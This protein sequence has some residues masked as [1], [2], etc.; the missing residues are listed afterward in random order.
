MWLDGKC[1]HNFCRD[2]PRPYDERLSKIMVL[3]LKYLM[4]ESGAVYGYT[5]SDEISL[6]L[7]A[8]DYK[9]QMYFDGKIQKITSVL[10]SCCV[11]HFNE[12]K[13]TMLTDKDGAM[14]LFD[15]RV[16]NVPDLIEAANYILWRE[17]DAVR[18]SISMAAQSVFSHT[19]L[20]GASCN[21]MQDMLHDKGI[22]WNDY[23][24]FF[25]RGTHVRRIRKMTKFST[26]EIEKLPDKHESRKNPD[27]EIERSVL[28]D[29]GIPKFSSISNKVGFMFNGEEPI[30]GDD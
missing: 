23:P 3:V 18:N 28:E 12:L 10:A 6:I 29:V 25:K 15:C 8:D 20:H 14:A 4:D 26:E 30:S 1:F 24:P 5:Q 13:R 19:E 21:R 2:L 27:L 11:Y 9:S 16:W 17:Q 7:Y 22:N